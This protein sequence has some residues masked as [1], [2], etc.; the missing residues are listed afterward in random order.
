MLLRHIIEAYRTHITT[1]LAGG[2][3]DATT[4]YDELLAEN[5]ELKRRC[6]ALEKKEKKKVKRAPNRYQQ[7]WSEEYPN[8]V[9]R[10]KSEDATS[11]QLFMGTHTLLA[12]SHQYGE[13]MNTAPSPKNGEALQKEDRTSFMKNVS[14]RAKAR[15]AAEEAVAAAEVAPPPTPKA[16]GFS[17]CY[18]LI[19]KG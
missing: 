10:A 14:A 1:E 13:N 17:P 5:S 2:V 15:K 4:A 16:V 11:E 9:L 19:N 18:V 6:K 3:T 8:E 7:L 12:Y